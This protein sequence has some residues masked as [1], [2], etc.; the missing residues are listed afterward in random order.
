VLIFDHKSKGQYNVSILYAWMKPPH[1]VPIG[2]TR[3]GALAVAVIS[4]CF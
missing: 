3:M 4:A 1:P 2:F